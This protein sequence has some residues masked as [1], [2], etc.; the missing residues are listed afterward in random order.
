[1][2][3]RPPVVCFAAASAFAGMPQINEATAAQSLPDIHKVKK[4][5]TPSF[6]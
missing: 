4:S 2:N 6:Q 1:M 3:P 5:L